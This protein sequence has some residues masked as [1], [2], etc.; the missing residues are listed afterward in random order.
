MQIIRVAD[1]FRV[2]FGD[3]AFKARLRVFEYSKP[4]SQK[5]YSIFI[6]NQPM[7]HVEHQILLK[8]I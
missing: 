5:E 6:A 7:F 8:K 3:N 4:V 1:I 2:P